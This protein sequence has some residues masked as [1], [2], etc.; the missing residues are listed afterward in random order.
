MII[1]GVFFLHFLSKVQK[2]RSFSLRQATRGNNIVTD[3]WAEAYKSATC[4]MRMLTLPTKHHG[5][6]DGLDLLKSHES[7]IKNVFLIHINLQ[8]M[9]K[10]FVKKKEVSY[11]YMLK[12]WRQL[13][14]IK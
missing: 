8:F 2:S 3:G 6:T 11:Q 14:Q 10:K 12:C 7:A 5:R 13:L 4:E 1:C 9:E